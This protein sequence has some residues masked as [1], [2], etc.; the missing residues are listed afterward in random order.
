[1][2]NFVR[3]LCAGT[4]LSLVAFAAQPA[5]AQSPP[6]GD[7][8]SS[9]LTPAQVAAANALAETLDNS[10]KGVLQQ[11]SFDSSQNLQVALDNAIES[12][13]E[14]SNASPAIGRAAI[15]QATELLI[16]QDLICIANQSLESRPDACE[17]VRNALSLALAAA[18][19]AGQVCA[20]S[21]GDGIPALGPPPPSNDAGQGPGVTHPGVTPPP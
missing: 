10:V 8:C 15:Q 9:K 21:F 19:N 7:G 13:L 4:L 12:I 2:S 3:S 14:N 17:D 20:A 6:L 1:M 18:K 11:A 16:S 5:S